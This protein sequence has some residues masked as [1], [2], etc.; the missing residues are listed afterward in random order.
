MRTLLAISLLASLAG[1]GDSKGED[2]TT[3]VTGV[4]GV[5][6]ITGATAP[7]TLTSAS[8]TDSGEP[9]GTSDMTAGPTSA[10]GTG[11]QA[12][13]TADEDCPPGEHCAPW[14][15]VCVAP[16]G[17]EVNE[18]CEPGL[19]CVDGA[20]EIGGCGAESFNLT[21]VPPN[22]MIVLDRSGSMDGD[23]QDS[24]KPRW[25]VAKDAISLLV[26]GFNE[27]IRFGLDTYSSCIPGQECSA[28]SI[29]VPLGNLAAGPITGFLGGKGL[30]YLCNSGDPE[31]STGNT[32]Y[33][34][35][36]EPSLQDPMRSNAVLLITDGGENGECQTVTNG[37]DAAGKL[38]SQTI[39]VKTFAVG[40]S[41]EVIDSLAGIA[42]AGG[43]DQPFNANNPASLEAA[44]TAIAGAVAS[45][46]FLL[47]SVPED[48]SKIYVFFDDDP[49]GVPLDQTNG[50][51][52]DPVTN[53]I[54]FHG[55]SC[56][57]IQNVTV[58]DVDVVFG[59]NV[60]VPG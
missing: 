8:T 46:Q 47:D 17:C 1:C 2:A 43:T 4:T 60:P 18:D 37:Q 25:E 23:V 22:V 58:K 59:C 32:L 56:A 44:L 45:C 20:C 19:Q 35:I 11:S 7:T 14:S 41:D 15:E 55:T 9:T 31:T 40:F 34:L 57:A 53:T 36:G 29:V 26:N 24:D 52:Y 48:P 33:A 3:G 27:E 12:E 6:G 21:A 13:C 10:E 38:L 30:E 54:T 42:Q 51:T 16:N 50:W 49:A 39:P 28:G 5:T